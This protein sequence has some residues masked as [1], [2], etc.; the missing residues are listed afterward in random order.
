VM[1]VAAIV[2]FVLGT[3]YLTVGYGLKKKAIYTYPL[4]PG[5]PDIV[6]GASA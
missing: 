1:F 2:L 4:T 6:F 3:R 5:N